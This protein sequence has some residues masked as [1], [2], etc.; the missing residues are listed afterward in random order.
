MPA[1]PAAQV[2]KETKAGGG[3]WPTGPKRHYWA[4]GII[5]L[6][7]FL[8]YKVS[9]ENLI[10][11]WDDPGYIRDNALIKDLSAAGLKNI[12]STAIMGNYHPLTILTYAIEYSFVRLDPWLYHL[13][14]VLLHIMVT[15]LVYVFVQ[16]LTKRPIAAAVTALLF[17]LH[18]MHVESVAWLAG[19]KDVLYGTFYMAACIGYLYYKRAEGSKK[20][21]W[22]GGIV[23][24]F[25][26]SLLAKPVAVTLPVALLAID[27]FEEKKW[28]MGLLLEKLP[29]LGISIVFGIRSMIDQKAFGS[30]ATQSV[31]YNAIERLAVGGYA[32]I[33][34]LWKAI[35]PV[36]LSCFYPY[37]PKTNN[38][39]PAQYYAY[40][41]AAVA[42][43]AAL[44]PMRKNKVVMFG[45]LFF[46]IN[47]VLLLQFIPVGGAILADRYSYIPYLGLFFIAGWYVSVL[48]EEGRD[49]QKGYVAL[50]GMGIYALALGMATTDRCK[51]WYDTATLWRDEIEKQ[52][53]APNA[54]NNLG[55]HYFNKFNESVNDAERRLCYDSAYYL[56]NQA[57]SLD[58]KFVNPIVS[59]GELQRG[60]ARYPEAKNYYY[61]ALR[62][63]NAEGNANAYLGLAI[64]YAI[65]QNLDS[66]AICFRNAIASKPYFPEVH[67]NYG[68]FFDMKGMT[69]SAL[70]HYSIAI[71]QNPDMYAPWLN[72]G[73][74][75]QR[76][77]R[78][79]EGMKDFET[80]LALMPDMGEIY[81]SRSYC[82]TQKGNKS[83]ALQDVERALQLGFKQVDPAYYQMLKS[84]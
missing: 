3:S 16:M 48:F 71:Q 62:L 23:L 17:G 32:F 37:P 80:A 9:L 25:L 12:L 73:R 46:L 65:T 83:A 63:N 55:F 4:V 34:Y 74:L 43:L 5:A 75:Y 10:T 21:M 50:G 70:V 13:D 38:I 76:M 8:F 24:L 42:I 19:R 11:N 79:D 29:L 39:L 28:R 84:R 35:V 33:T 60:A 22:Y 47:I 20:W 61:A 36:N 1:R 30:L 82:Y 66:S 14:N 2:N 72:R 41:A 31:D 67:S 40:I 69:D 18:P 53:L 51:A 52:P 54:W 49:K 64:T 27:L 81:Y 59:M 15:A 58:P 26:C 6:L 56:L 57:I 77:K 68:N 45:A 78:C 44:W 7:T